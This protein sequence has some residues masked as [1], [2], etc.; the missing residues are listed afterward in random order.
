MSHLHFF[1]HLR[2]RGAVRRAEQSGR[3]ELTH[4]NSSKRAA[5]R[6]YTPQKRTRPCAGGSIAISNRKD[7]GLKQ[8]VELPKAEASA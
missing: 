6:G 5:S 3:R 1:L 8:V 4:W 7:G 2:K